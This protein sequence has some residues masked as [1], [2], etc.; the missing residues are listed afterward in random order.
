MPKIIGVVNTSFE[1]KDGSKVEGMTIHVLDEI[2]TKRGVGQSADHFFI[3]SK[4]IAELDFKP[5]VG[6]DIQTL[7]NKYGRVQTLRLLDEEVID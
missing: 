6:Q 7:Y 1:A 3:S 2:D 4:K 5:S